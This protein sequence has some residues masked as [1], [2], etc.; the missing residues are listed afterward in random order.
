MECYSAEAVKQMFFYAQLHTL[1]Q[2]GIIGLALVVIAGW[3]K[4]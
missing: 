4:K 3:Y 2:F 1:V